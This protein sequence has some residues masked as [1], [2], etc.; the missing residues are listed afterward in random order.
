MTITKSEYMLFLKHPAWLWLKKNDKSTLPPIDENTQAVF[1]IGN[2]F[3]SYAEQLFPDGVRIGFDNHDEYLSLPAR[4]TEALKDGA[5][6][7]FQGRFEH[8]QLTFICDVIK[9]VGDKTV[10]LYE[11]KSSTKAKAEH[12]YD[13]AFQMEVLERCGFTVRTIS[14]IH[15]NNQFV[16]AGEVDPTDITATTDVTVAVRAKRELTKQNIDEA[17][18][19]ISMPAIPS[20]S[21]ALAKLGYFSEW[22]GIYKRLA[23]TEPDSVYDL[24]GLT[25][26]LV[27]EFESQGISKMADIPGD[28]ALSVKQQLQLQAVKEGKAL[29]STS[30]IKEHLDTF[31]YPLYF[32]DYET[33]SGIV[34][35]FDGL[36]PYCQLPF[37][38]SLHILDAPGAEIRHVEYLHRDNSDPSQPLSMLL[39]SHIGEQGSVVTWNMGFEKGC[40]PT[41]GKQAPEFKEFY[42]QLNLRIVDLMIPFSRCWYVD[43]SFKGSASI[44]SVLPVLVPELSY[45]TLGIQEGGS[46][47]RLWMEAVLDGKRDDQKE[48][49]F[50]DLVEYCGLDTLA[51]VEIYKK[52]LNASDTKLA[53]N[54]SL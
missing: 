44:K 42:E 5:T 48:K 10:D 14:V 33:M 21:P 16:R 13:L 17:L 15:V 30:K 52:L 4:T 6:T 25:A 7:I 26:K 12:I 38:Y 8:E 32:F 35:Y 3:E 19:V 18:R 47:Q 50:S 40:N 53:Y 11:I 37:Q 51:M 1:D 20:I 22:L 39:Q 27:G 28:F 45:K 9:I 2:L 46:A 31:E 29:M 24:C 34:P 49:I 23:G 36:K 41:I 43:K 54:S